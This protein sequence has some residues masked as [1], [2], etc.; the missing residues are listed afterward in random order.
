MFVAA[1]SPLQRSLVPKAFEERTELALGALA[2]WILLRQKVPQLA[3]G[4]VVF[5]F[6]R[7]GCGRAIELLRNVERHHVTVQR[8]RLNANVVHC[9]NQ[10][11]TA[12]KEGSVQASRALRGL[13]R[14]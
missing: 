13:I 8:S 7:D 2:A 11:W 12:V 9:P 10:V 3:R 6:Q 4:V 1:S 14:K 5:R